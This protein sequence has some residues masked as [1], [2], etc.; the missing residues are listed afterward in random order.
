MIDLTKITTRQDS[1][2]YWIAT[3]GNVSY[4]DKT[5]AKAIQGLWRIEGQLKKHIKFYA[6]KLAE[7]KGAP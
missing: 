6:E 3:A 5:Q 4:T 7:I 1:D 2:G